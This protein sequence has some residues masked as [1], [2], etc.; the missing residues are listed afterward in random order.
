MY[1]KGFFPKTYPFLTLKP[2]GKSLTKKIRSL[3]DFIFNGLIDVDEYIGNKTAGDNIQ[4]LL[5]SCNICWWQNPS[6]SGFIPSCR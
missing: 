6:E 1:L 2:K 3:F 4:I 5:T